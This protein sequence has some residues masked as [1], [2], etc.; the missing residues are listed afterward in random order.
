MGPTTKLL[1]GATHPGKVRDN[2][3]DTFIAERIQ[4]NR[5]IL[6]CVIDGVGGYE[7]GEV[8]AEIARKTILSHLDEASDDLFASMKNALAAAN[9]NIHREKQNNE[10]NSM[11]A[12]VLTLAIAD[13]T[14]NQFYYAHVGDTRLY[15]LRDHTL[16][17]ITR[18][19]SFVG[20][21]EDSKR[22]SEEESMRHPKRNEID[23]ALG[24]HPNM[25]SIGDYVE[26]GVSPFLPGDT[27][28]LC[29]DGLSDMI[30]SKLIT[31][32]LTSKQPLAK[33]ADAL[34][35]AANEA[36]GKDNVT[37]VI[38]Q[39]TNKPV[40]QKATKPTLLKKNDEANEEDTV[41]ESVK[42][43]GRRNSGLIT[44]ALAILCILLLAAL[45]WKIFDRDEEDKPVMEVVATQPRNPGED[46]LLD[47]IHKT[48]TLNLSDSAFGKIILLSDSI[49]IRQDSL[50]ING[51]GIVLK[52][53][54]SFSG[55]ALVVAEN[56]KY[57]LLENLAFEDFATAIVSNTKMV[58]LKNI[59]FSKGGIALQEKFI[60]P[61][62]Q[63]VNGTLADTTFFKTDTVPVQK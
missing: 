49:V 61:P 11:M 50:T 37:V 38:L 4:D 43:A 42:P 51:N 59:R 1:A 8:A 52:R 14:N 33:K 7:G 23:K 54:S 28:L 13:L 21:L 48:R 35:H 60:F 63:Y 5:F 15:L 26:T 6:G 62:G 47:T 18:D 19:H 34:I 46:R 58:Y 16:V 3:E 56:V 25:A 2:N 27:L 32:I 44:K 45:L 12:C 41:E 24:F 9:D 29:S 10:S 36:G 31:S 40:I 17:K 53:D 39:N 20:F 22:L 55:P 30:D 57:L